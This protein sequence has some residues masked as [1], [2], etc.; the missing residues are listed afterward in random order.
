MID[1]CFYDIQIVGFSASG[2]PDIHCVTCVNF[3][4]LMCACNWFCFPHMMINCGI[5]YVSCMKLK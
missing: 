1:T 3:Y 2:F 4:V 5:D